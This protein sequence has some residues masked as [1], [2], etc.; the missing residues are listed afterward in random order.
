MILLIL[1]IE[2]LESLAGLMSF[3]CIIF[4]FMVAVMVLKIVLS[5]MED[6]NIYRSENDNNKNMFR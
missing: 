5:H 4:A 3:I 1:L 6:D 2:S